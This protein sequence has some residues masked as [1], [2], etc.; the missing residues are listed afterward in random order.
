MLA[1]LAPVLSL[2]GVEA[3][4]ITATIKRRA[5]VW[6]TI[7]AFGVV[8]IVFVLVAIDS[9]LADQVG[10]VVAP[11][12]IAVCAGLIAVIVFL[13]AQIQ[14]GIA[15]R[16]EAERRRSAEASGLVTTAL[17]GALPMILKHPL[18]REVGIPAGAAIA[19]SLLLRNAL[20]R[21]RDSEPRS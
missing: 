21:D 20:P 12:I 11:L 3:A 4:S 15:A 7:A 17:L 14:D 16:R 6:G 5:I 9:A 10:P 8:A 13:I 18:M 19:S 1:V 2:L